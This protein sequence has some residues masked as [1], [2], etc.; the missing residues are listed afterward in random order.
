MPYLTSLPSPLQPCSILAV[1]RGPA[2]HLRVQCYL[3]LRRS[4][5]PS[6]SI[7]AHMG[8]GEGKGKGG[9]GG[10]L[11]GRS[12]GTGCLSTLYAFGRV[13]RCIRGLATSLHANP[14]NHFQLRA[15]FLG[16]AQ[17]CL[18]WMAWLI[19]PC[20]R[21]R[22]LRSTHVLVDVHHSDL[23]E[24]SLPILH[25][26]VRECTG[27]HLASTTA[28]S[29]SFSPRVGGPPRA[30][31][32]TA[33]PRPACV[34][35]ASEDKD[36]SFYAPSSDDTSYNTSLPSPSPHL[37][38]HS[39]SAVLRDPE[40][41]DVRSGGCVSARWRCNRPIP[42][43][44]S[45]GGEG[46]GEGM[47][48]RKGK[49]GLGR[50]RG[51]AK[52]TA[53]KTSGPGTSLGDAHPERGRSDSVI[54]LVEEDDRRGWKEEVA[55]E[56]EGGFEVEWVGEG[57]DEHDD[58]DREEEEQRGVSSGKLL[59]LPRDFAL[60]MEQRTVRSL[61]L[62]TCTRCD[63]AARRRPRELLRVLCECVGRAIRPATLRRTVHDFAVD[64]YG[65]PAI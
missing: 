33:P 30:I 11:W 41:H 62:R 4:I 55:P 63:G 2:A 9:G 28:P 13:D 27:R 7:H 10:E 52:G 39:I 26:P 46:R 35:R 61:R 25:P 42:C 40:A 20:V 29:P 49:G 17:G 57:E 59:V 23:R 45:E 47:R 37:R 38:P 50:G 65:G 58:E 24:G 34:T 51:N 32:N 44:G 14:W 56:G 54:K 6:V 1:Q 21:S 8:R 19:H 15:V 60:Y 18:I 12:C 5:A 48:M 64:P 16:G 36:R 3:S 22:D 53:R 31:D 43:R